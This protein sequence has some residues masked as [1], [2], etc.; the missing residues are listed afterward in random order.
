MVVRYGWKLW[1]AVYGFLITFLF[2]GATAGSILAHPLHQKLLL[3]EEVAIKI[4]PSQAERLERCDLFLSIFLPAT[5]S[6][7]NP[8]LQAIYLEKYR[9]DCMDL[10]NLLKGNSPEQVLVPAQELRILGPCQ[11]RILLS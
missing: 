8:L 10:L 4:P 11:P 7:L 6:L 9:G 3:Q 2:I 1:I 5:L